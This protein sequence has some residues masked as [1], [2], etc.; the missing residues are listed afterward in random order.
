MTTSRA[1][2]VRPET[3]YPIWEGRPCTQQDCDWLAPRLTAETKAEIEATSI[4]PID[5]ALALDLRGKRAIA[6]SRRSHQPDALLYWYPNPDGSAGIWVGWTDRLAKS[7]HELS[8]ASYLSPI[9]DNLN[10]YYP[11]LIAGV[12]ARDIRRTALMTNLGFE[13]TETFPQ[14]GLKDLPFHFFTRI[15]SQSHV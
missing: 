10:G 9:I 3:A 5:K 1:T 14:Y 8:F 7:E 2:S 11:R 4:F 15:K 12:D 13:L 6:D